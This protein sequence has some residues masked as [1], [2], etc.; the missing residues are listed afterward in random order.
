MT[1]RVR[2]E[3]VCEG[4]NRRRG[5]SKFRHE[6]LNEIVETE[7]PTSDGTRIAKLGDIFQYRAETA[8][9]ICQ[10][11]QQASAPSNFSNGKRWDDWKMD[12]LKRHLHHKVHLE[13]VCRLRFQIALDVERILNETSD[14]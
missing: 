3:T 6:W 9:V 12:Y 13:S 14:R 5:S 7:L 4:G 11:C 2:G 1:D 10:V 8:D